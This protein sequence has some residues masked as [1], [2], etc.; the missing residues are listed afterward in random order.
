MARYSFAGS[1]LK[2][3]FVSGE[4]M[5]LKRR[6]KTIQITKHSGELKKKL[7]FKMEIYS[8]SD[9]SKKHVFGLLKRI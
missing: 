8:G 1:Y 6:D 5:Q 2:F 7:S 9:R 3:V 4:S